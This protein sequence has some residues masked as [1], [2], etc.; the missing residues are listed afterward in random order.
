MFI[1]DEKME[2]KINA[3]NNLFL[4]IIHDYQ[5]LNKYQFIVNFR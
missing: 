2:Y 4:Q 1:M 3:M 5:R